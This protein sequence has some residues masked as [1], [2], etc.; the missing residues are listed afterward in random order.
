MINDGESFLSC[1]FCVFNNIAIG[2]LHALNR[3]ANPKPQKVAIV[4]FDVHHGNGTEEIV[5]KYIQR[6]GD[7]DSLF[8]FSVHLWDETQDCDTFKTT[9]DPETPE[10]GNGN[11]SSDNQKPVKRRRRVKSFGD[12][13]E[14]EL[15]AGSDVP[16]PESCVSQTSAHTS[17]DTATP[18]PK[19]PNAHAP[20]EDDVDSDAY[21][22]TRFY[23]GS[24]LRD[25]I[26][27]NIINCPI[28]PL[29][30]TDVQYPK[31]PDNVATDALCRG[32]QG[33][34]AAIKRRLLPALRAYNPDLILIS[35]GFDGG[36]G[37]AGNLSSDGTKGGLDLT[38]ED[39]EWMMSQIMRVSRICCPGRV[40][41][42]M[43]GGYGEWKMMEGVFTDEADKKGLSPYL[44]RNNLAENCIRHFQSILLNGSR[45]Q[46]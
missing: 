13:Y 43:E 8:F 5:K 22:A 14:C 28:R 12:D 11:S 45:P 6:T 15:P 46:K 3:V 44:K 2:A 17:S 4:D 9:V 34:R 27:G 25:D 39:Y 10:N 18:A 42:V 37:D 38:A 31:S 1:G 19:E 7:I 24:G 30:R 21:K 29:W 16:R 36:R 41:S 33:V 23:P 40:V 20:V 26:F 35:A 32:R